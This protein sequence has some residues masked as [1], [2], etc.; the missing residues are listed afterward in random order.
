V[1]FVLGTC[2]PDL[3]G[4]VPSMV[5]TELRWSWT[6]IPEWAIYV[7]APLHMPLGIVVGG[8]VCAFLFPEAGRAKVCRNL[9]GGGLLHMLVDTLQSHYGV[10]YLL[11][12]PFSSWDFEFGLIGSED[13]VRI[14]PFL[15]PMTAL[16]CWLR[17]R[18]GAPP[19]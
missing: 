12:F 13:T 6:W 11:L 3:L 18:K 5:L 16:A 10:G 2:L 19:R 15:L 1:V 8:W 4:R 17:W 7:W 14:A 9:V